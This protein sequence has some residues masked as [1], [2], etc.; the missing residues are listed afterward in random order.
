[1]YFLDWDY[2]SVFI[3]AYRYLSGLYDKEE[4]EFTLRRGRVTA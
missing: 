4:V 1:M 3:E 2:A